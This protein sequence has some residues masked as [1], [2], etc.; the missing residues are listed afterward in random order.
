MN[1]LRICFFTPKGDLLL[2][3][4][5][6]KEAASFLEVA[7]VAVKN[8]QTG[9]NLKDLQKQFATNKHS[10]EEL[11]AGLEKMGATVWAFEKVVKFMDCVCGCNCI[12]LYC[13]GT[14]S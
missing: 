1:I 14:D 2:R 7:S 4:G 5:G 8:L 11:R 12:Y 3:D 10:K 13:C 9:V 6:S